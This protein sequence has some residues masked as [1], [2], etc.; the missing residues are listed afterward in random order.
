MKQALKQ[1]RSY[2][3]QSSL[4]V[5]ALALGIATL[6]AAYSVLTLGWSNDELWK[7]EIKLQDVNTA[8]QKVAIALREITNANSHPVLFDEANLTD[9]KQLLPNT[10][11]Y[12]KTS[13]Q[14]TITRLT[15][16][17]KTSISYVSQDY[18]NA[19]KVEVARGGLLSESDFLERR[20]VILLD[21]NTAK[22]LQATVAQQLEVVAFNGSR[23]VVT[24][25]G[26]LAADGAQD[27][28][29]P[30]GSSDSLPEDFQTLTITV[31]EAE[32][33]SGVVELL[34]SQVHRT[35]GDRVVVT[36]PN[37]NSSTARLIILVVFSFASLGLL[38]A[39]LNIMNLMLAR[40][41]SQTRS[42]GIMRALGASRENTLW[43]FIR[44]SL[45]LGFLGG[46]FGVLLGL[47]LVKLYL[48]YLASATEEVVAQNVFSWESIPIGLFISL[49][50]TFVF[51]F[52]PALRASRLKIVDALNSAL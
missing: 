6:T 30:Y 11:V 46:I 39:S 7:R 13:W 28:I 16:T 25:V 43:R 48:S 41:M 29:M 52:Y 17:Q 45:L 40:I 31:N 14:H 38:A 42:I 24:V 36:A 20:N 23:Q 47:G 32:D 50:A 18:L 27:S 2:P 44:E 49:V 3:F 4:I 5:I 51:G 33:I 35:W 34:S 10:H 26:V 22:K 19:A 8:P 12:V 15:D 21:A 1:F 9:L 37:S